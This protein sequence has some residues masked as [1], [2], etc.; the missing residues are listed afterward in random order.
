MVLSD[1]GS[2]DSSALLCH[3]NRPRS[4]RHSGGDWFSPDG[5][6]V[7]SVS[8]SVV[9]GFE[10]NR[11]PMLVRLRRADSN[12]A[13]GIYKCEVKDESGTNQTVFVGIYIN[14]EGK[15]SHIFLLYTSQ[16]Y[17]NYYIVGR[18]VIW[19]T[20][21]HLHREFETVSPQFTLTCISTGGPATTVTWTRDSTT[22]TE[23]T[24]T[25]LNDPVTAQY[26]HNLTVNGRMEGVYECL[27]S[28]IYYQ[29]SA[30]IDVKGILY[31]CIIIS[32]STVVLSI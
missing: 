15:C 29:N 8:S 7:G 25:V 13:N 17:H 27:I 20:S 30:S 18:I 26:T 16:L 12:A 3:T 28:N 5:T 14:A 9:P 21:F 11:G 2:N 32:L 19:N 4:G 22:V 23:G 6:R 31:N 1:I 10:R 24:E